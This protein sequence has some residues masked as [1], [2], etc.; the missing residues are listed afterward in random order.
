MDISV[1]VPVY[2]VEE[3]LVECLE[4]VRRNVAGLHAE[5]LLI[6]DGSTDNSSIIARL[7][8]E[9]LDKF[10]Y[11]RTENGG[12]SRAR[13]YG[14]SLAK[15][16]YLF[17][18][19]SDDML[20]DG[21]LKKMLETAERNGTE[22]TVCNVARYRNGKA[23]ESFLH[24][25]AFHGLRNTVS[26]ITKHP[27][28]I[29]D[30]TTWNKLILRSFYKKQNI[31]FPDGYTY[32]DM[33]PYFIM[34]YHCNAVSVI[35]ETGY[36]Y[37]SRT[38][39]NKQ[40]T[41]IIDK[42]RLTDIIEMMTQA[43]MYARKQAVSSDIMEALETKFL[44]FDFDA[45]FDRIPLLPADEAVEYFNLIRNFVNKSIDKEYIGKIPLIKQQIYNDIL[46]GDF[47]HLLRVVNYKNA[48]YSRAPVIENDGRL[49]L[50]LPA[51]IFTIE[52]RSAAHEF[53]R[54]IQPECIINS[55]TTTGSSV[56]IQGRLFIRRISVPFHNTGFFKAFLLNE[57]TG[58]MFPLPV[59]P[60]RKHDLT[61]LQ[62]NVLN[63]DDYSYCRY[64]YDGAGFQMDVDFAQ[65]VQN[66]GF[67]G[68]NY[69][70]LI[71]DFVH[72]RGDWLLKGITGNARTKAGKFIFEDKEH[73]GKITFD[74]QNIIRVVLDMKQDKKPE[75]PG[76][77]ILRSIP[78]EFK[79]TMAGKQLV[80]LQKENKNLQKKN[81]VLEKENKVLLKRKEELDKI[82]NSNGY[83]ALKKYYKVRGFFFK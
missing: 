55:V 54:N 50:K 22:L 70:I 17:F 10:L 9:K 51:N 38:G 23:S 27:N 39:P 6:D 56:S 31:T 49:E 47:G 4:S 35:H 40:I 34:H 76:T 78:V 53:G 2:N 43:I 33:V 65:L 83:K 77:D 36:L 75:N 68:N 59:S 80:K 46:Q 1:I 12:L 52:S 15:G 69:I 81:K 48:N 79:S 30:S 73:I 57:T 21:I 26:H 72:C 45:W 8:A 29:F 71:Y 67:I 63:Y 3:F 64:D 58:C 18:M 16:K 37:R 7:Y 41:Q 60:F 28:L 82:K 5:V 25:R 20:T 44:I 32:E 24:L 61:E 66:E 19:D 14:V 62:G 13:N 42:K 74:A 11:Y